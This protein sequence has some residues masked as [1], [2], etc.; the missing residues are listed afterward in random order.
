MSNTTKDK[1]RCWYCGLADKKKLIRCGCGKYFCNGTGNGKVSHIIH[2]AS[3]LKHKDLK[4]SDEY[5]QCNLCKTRNPFVLGFIQ[6]KQNSD[7][8]TCLCRTCR[9]NTTIKNLG[10]DV[11]SWTSIVC[12]GKFVNEI[13]PQPSNEEMSIVQSISYQKM[14]KMAWELQNNRK[15]FEEETETFEELHPIYLNYHDCK[16]Y[17]HTYYPLI[18]LEAE[19]DRQ[20]RESEHL[21]NMTLT[22]DGTRTEKDIKKVVHATFQ[23]P[24]NEEIS[25]T[26]SDVLFFYVPMKNKSI[27]VHEIHN[28]SEFNE[29]ERKEFIGK[30]NTFLVGGVQSI[31]GKDV[32]VLLSRQADIPIEKQIVTPQNQQFKYSI[33]FQWL[34][35]PFHRKKEALLDFCR[36]ENEPIEA[37]MSK[38]LRDRLLGMP[39]TEMDRQMEQQF[40]EEKEMYL[41]SHPTEASLSAPNLPPLNQVQFDVVRK[42]F[43]KQ[44]SLIQGPPGTGKTVTS[45]T[46]VY[47]VV[48]SNPGKKVLVCAPSNI[49][50]DQLGTKITETGV[51]VIRV[52]S[53]SRET[54][55]E[56]LYDYSLKTLM[57]EKLKKDKEMFALYQEYKDDPDSLDFV[58]T[59]TIQKRINQIELSLLRETDVICCTCCGALD[60]RLSG[61]LEHIDTVLID[62]STQADEPECLICLNNSVKQLFLVGDH[63]QLGPILNSSR[64][65]KYGLGLP[66]FSRL[67]QL[68]HEPYRL[69]FQYRMHP[70][71]SEFS[72]QTFYDGVLQNGVTALERQFPSL[73]YFW[74]KQ[75]KPMMFIAA[76]GKESYGSN[77]T[78]YI[79]DEEVF[80]IEQIIIKMLGNKV[81]PSQIGVITPYIAQKQAII[82]RLS[83][84]RRISEAQLN[85]I[86][87]A[88]VDSFQGREKDFIIFST[89]R[90]NEISDIGFLSIP[91][92]LNVSITRAKYGLVVVGNPETLMQNPL[93]CAYLQFF[94]NN[95][96]LV[97]GQLEN[98]KEYPIKLEP[99][100]APKAIYQFTP[101][102]QEFSDIEPLKDIAIPFR[103]TRQQRSTFNPLDEFSI[104]GGKEDKSDELDV[105]I[106]EDESNESQS[107]VSDYDEDDGFTI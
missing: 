24:L 39:I 11:D 90:S 19:A 35:I 99:K 91:Q 87:I 103:Q 43:T 70:C 6:V 83:L 33:C 75:N 2:H 96:V 54:E 77:G 62:E 8:T 53:K 71:L 76:N 12:E 42:S 74:F 15:K 10:W 97:H 49:A 41:N 104:S 64:A 17:Y 57:E 88:S 61:I 13:C 72:S 89:V 82:S 65:K 63:C 18:R 58:S 80:I 38:Y 85:D 27:D 29:H 78:S 5:I 44:L 47:H 102:V 21:T 92:R 37:S 36:T 84:N 1:V 20:K 68:G 98:L 59:A 69:Q 25:I 56:S 34:S 50:V 52:Y 105:T 16:Q 51:K 31:N 73:K 26:P 106:S 30:I 3:S 101:K 40:K 28:Y 22:F 100:E 94:Q 45:A 81:S 86:E 67:L 32:T 107:E 23:V 55:D 14:R 93:W 60:T 7:M 66:M 95:N 9:Y 46:I 48:Q 4:Y 79:N